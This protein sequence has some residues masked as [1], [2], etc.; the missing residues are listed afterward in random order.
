MLRTVKGKPLAKDFWPELKT[1]KD[2]KQ[3]WKSLLDPRIETFSD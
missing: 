1:P 3:F 2:K